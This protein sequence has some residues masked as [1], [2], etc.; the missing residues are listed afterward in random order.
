MVEFAL[1]GKCYLV[2]HQVSQ[3]GETVMRRTYIPKH[4]PEVIRANIRRL[5]GAARNVHTTA[6]DVIEYKGVVLSS[7][8]QK[9]DE[10][11]LMQSM[12]DG[13]SPSL[14]KKVESIWC[15][16][17]AAACY[18]VL[19]IDCG[20]VSARDIGSRLETACLRGDGGHN[21]IYLYGNSGA[22]CSLDP[23]WIKG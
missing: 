14:R 10:L 3:I 16:S 23:V 11:T 19:L 22:N 2:R 15:D 8:Y 9:A 13:V 7:R 1:L 4:E 6:L 20:E 18:T 5:G 17:Q 12:V 21:G